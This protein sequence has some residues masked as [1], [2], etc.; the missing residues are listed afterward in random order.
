MRIVCLNYFARG[1]RMRAP[2]A[3]A[4]AIG[5]IVDDKYLVSGCKCLKVLS[6]M[7]DDRG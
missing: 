4:A 5:F 6:K 3:V 2:V 1:S 7:V